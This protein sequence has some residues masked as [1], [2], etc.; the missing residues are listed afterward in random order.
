MKHTEVND[1]LHNLQH[2]DV[3]LPPDA[4]AARTLEVVPVHHDMD[5]QVNRDGNPLH[6]GE[7]DELSVAQECGGAVVVGVE[8]GQRLLLEDQKDGVQ[9]FDVFVDIVELFVESCQLPQS[10]TFARHNATY[11][12]Q[13]DKRLS[14]SAPMITNGVEDAMARNGGQKLLDKQ[15]QQN[16]TDD[17]QE[18][19]VDHEQGVELE[20]GKLLHDL[21]A[22]EDHSVVGDQDSRGLLEGRQRSDTFDELELAGRVAHDLFICLV[23]QR[24]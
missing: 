3:L 17:S 8:E 23:E 19:V 18:Q 10:Q 22:T 5:Q 6:C 1:E 12:V 4:D 13:D 2:G 15:G 14:P 24:P 20:C 11:V 9:E 7:A 16:G 21:T